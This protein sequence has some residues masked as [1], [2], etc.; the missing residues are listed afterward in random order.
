MSSRAVICTLPTIRL[1]AIFFGLL[2]LPATAVK[3][4]VQTWSHPNGEPNASTAVAPG[5]VRSST[6]Y[7]VRVAPVT[8]P[9]QLHD[10]FVYMSVPRSGLGKVGYTDEDGAEFSAQA[11]MTMS[12]SS[13][14]H[15]EDV[16]VYVEL[17]GGPAL[18]S[19]DQVTIR[20]TRF[21]FQKELVSERTVRIRVPSVPEG[22]RF[23]VEFNSQ[24]MTSYEDPNGALTTEPAGNRA[25]HTEPRNGLMIFAEPILAGRDAARL[26][27][28]PQSTSYTIHYPAQGLLSNLDEVTDQVIYFRPGTYYMGGNH[29]ANLR[30]NVRW[31]YLAPGAY[32][33]GAFQFHASAAAL[34]ELTMLGITGFGVLSGEQYV[35]EADRANG[36]RR[37]APGTSDCHGTCVKLLE[38]DAT[39]AYELM[40]IHGITLANAS[41]HSFVVHGEPTIVANVSHGKQLG[42][43][44]WQT[45]GIEMYDNGT[46]SDMFFHLNDDVLKLYGS[47]TMVNGIVVW[48]LENGPV[49]QWGWTPRNIQ[50]VHVNGVDVIHNR[51]HRD[52]HNTCIINSARHYLDPGSNRLADPRALV[53]EML[54]SN[55]RSEG[56]NLCAMRLY[57]LS[58]WRNIHIANL[59]IEG[60]NGLD[61][62]RQASKFEALSNDAG[63]RVMIGNEIRD[64]MGLSLFNY[65]VGGERITK[66]AGNWRA[67]GPGRLDFD[68]A[69]WESWNAQ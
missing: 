54:L 45:D 2:L 27:P 23:S 18:T 8:Q 68:P 34:P 28:D 53:N 39:P 22:F 31:I 26:A 5:K 40:T 43:W 60:W 69:L 64:H 46:M 21:T 57:A 20:P 14:L 65:T 15:D 32:V 29:H 35:Y 24:Q 63:D 6:V 4:E 52:V 67:N 30:P 9:G 62:A 11:G 38:F 36:Y 66:E 7:Q 25:V 19:A 47:N 44:Y 3:A 1:V 55:I 37:R 13:F 10:S 61:S 56:M 48:K 49:F 33:K 51:M 58:S 16:W 50:R 17:V 41:Y 59:W 12:W 42:G